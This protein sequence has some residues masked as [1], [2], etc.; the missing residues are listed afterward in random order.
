MTNLAVASAY[1]K[2]YLLSL[3]F[4]TSVCDSFFC[5]RCARGPLH[6]Q[7]RRFFQEIK[8]IANWSTTVME[9]TATETINYSLKGATN[10]IDSSATFAVYF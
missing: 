3:K 1:L 8:K 4:G 9:V 5:Q 10:L 2:G 6:T 7:F